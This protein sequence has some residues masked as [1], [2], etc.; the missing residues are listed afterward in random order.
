[1][2]GNRFR[3]CAGALLAV[4]VLSGAALL[5]HGGGAVAT[6]ARGTLS[7]V[8]GVAPQ[9]T[10]AVVNLSRLAEGNRGAEGLSVRTPAPSPRPGEPSFSATTSSAAAGPARSPSSAATQCA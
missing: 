2:G 9:G 6:A 5:L 3:R 8:R 4:L 7:S 1:M 10:F